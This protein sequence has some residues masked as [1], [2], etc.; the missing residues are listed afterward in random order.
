MS[1]VQKNHQNESIGLKKTEKHKESLKFDEKQMRK[2]AISVNPSLEKK[3]I[4]EE[5]DYKAT[6]QQ[7]ITKFEE[8]NKS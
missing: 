8:L 3:E 5:S 6:V 1:E 7:L 4:I 2:M